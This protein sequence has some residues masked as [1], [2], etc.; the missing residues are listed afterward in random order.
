M[1]VTPIEKTTATQKEVAI[2]LSVRFSFFEPMA[3]ESKMDT[4]FV[5]PMAMEVKIKIIGVEFVKAAYAV[6]PSKLPIQRLSTRLYIIF[7][8][9]AATIGSAIASRQC[10][11]LPPIKSIFFIIVLPF[12]SNRLHRFKM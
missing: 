2:K 5:A 10:L 9:M 7:K 12:Y 1:T 11:V 3:W 6:S 4:P 8:N